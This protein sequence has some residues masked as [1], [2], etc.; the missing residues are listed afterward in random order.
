MSTHDTAAG[1]SAPG[2]RLT[3]GRFLGWM[4]LLLALL[5]GAMILAL[6]LGS[7]ELS[8]GAAL[9]GAGP[10]RVVLLEVRLPRVLLGAL[11]GA[12][13]GASGAAL[14]AI[15]RNPLADPFILGVSGGA[16]LG[17]T[18]ARALATGLFGVAGGT[19]WLG[20]G[21]HLAA[22]AGALGAVALTFGI[23]RGA[24]GARPY[25]LLLAGVVLNAFA[26]ALILFLRAAVAQDKAQELLYWLIGSLGYP[27]PL[28]LAS[29]A[30]LV[31]CGGVLL[32]LLGG[33]L[34]VLA[35]Q[36]RGAA[37]LGIDAERMR[38]LVIVLTSV[39]VGTTVSLAGLVGFVGL[40]VPHF[41]RLLTG[42]D[43][44]LLLP[45]SLLGGGA[46]LVLA[47]LS[48]RLLFRFLGTEPPV[49]VVTAF[50]GGPFFLWLMRRRG[51]ST[52]T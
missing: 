41:L 22:T 21:S 46:F 6:L 2:A 32:S 31:I 48:A 44:R 18:V 4:I 8:L 17:G 50:L 43:H 49:G 36:D 42:P 29:V 47:D 11:V 45:A 26:S 39:I 5:L 30:V 24:G 34:N 23:A 1:P 51:G 37:V 28:E 33:T 38:L 10:A 19:L 15:L 20:L 25:A 40:M 9:E 16:A 7:T 27:T 3:A 35:L 52:L 12:G 14:Q 13:L